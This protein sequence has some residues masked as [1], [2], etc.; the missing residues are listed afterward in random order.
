MT[1]I[2]H[3]SAGLIAIAMLTTSALGSSSAIAAPHAVVKSHASAA[4]A[5]RWGDVQARISMPRVGTFDALPR[6]E[7]GGICDHGDNPAIC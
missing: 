1:G 6:D 4:A 3:I 7:P 5:G 2:K